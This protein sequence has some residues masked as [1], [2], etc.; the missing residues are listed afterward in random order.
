[1]HSGLDKNTGS[2]HFR[3]RRMHQNVRILY[4][5]YTKKIPGVATPGPPRQKGRHLFA[6]TPV[7]TCQM[8]VP[9]RIFWA[10][11][12][13]APATAYLTHNDVDDMSLLIIM[14]IYF[15]Y[16]QQ[17]KQ[18]LYRPTQYRTSMLLFSTVLLSSAISANK[19]AIGL[20]AWDICIFCTGIVCKTC[21]IQSHTLS[22]YTE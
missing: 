22:A 21:T 5:K 12:G 3:S 9:L 8:L 14:I 10:G 2:V 4:L 16:V 6:P 1:M 13:P 7:P 20:T 11:Y 15:C 19:R 17:L 18:S